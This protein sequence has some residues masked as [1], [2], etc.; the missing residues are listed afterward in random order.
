MILLR[1][2][3]WGFYDLVAHFCSCVR[4]FYDLVGQLTLMISLELSAR[5]LWSFCT[6]YVDEFSWVRP[7]PGFYDPIVCPFML[8]IFL[9]SGKNFMILLYNLCWWFAWHECEDFMILMHNLCWW[10]CLSQVQG[11]YDL[12][13]QF[14]LMTLPQSYEDCIIFLYSLCWWSFAW[15]SWGYYDLVVYIWWWWFCLNLALRIHDLVVCEFMLM[16]FVAQGSFQDQLQKFLRRQT[17]IGNLSIMSP[18][19]IS[20]STWSRWHLVPDQLDFKPESDFMM[21]IDFNLDI[22]D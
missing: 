15:V 18:C 10:F 2:S 5:I 3:V 21:S 19:L 17:L 7:V 22:L 8:I 1:S 16:M 13:A 4:I 12:V 11:F 9:E 14:M 6:I 20:R